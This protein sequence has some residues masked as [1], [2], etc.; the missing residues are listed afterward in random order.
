[1]GK[2]DGD[3]LHQISLLSNLF[4]INVQMY[5]IF[6]LKINQKEGIEFI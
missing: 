6:W 1:M 2:L 5:M 4:Y 3:P